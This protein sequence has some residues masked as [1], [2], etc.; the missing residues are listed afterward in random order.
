M[1]LNGSCLSSRQQPNILHATHDMRGASDINGER[2]GER[3]PLIG[4]IKQP[5]EN[6][7]AEQAR[8]RAGPRPASRSCTPPRHHTHREF[9][10]LHY[11]PPRTTHGLDWMEWD[12]M[13]S[14]EMRWNGM[15]W[16]GMECMPH[17]PTCGM[18]YIVVFFSFVILPRNRT[19]NNTLWPDWD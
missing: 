12:E 19:T 14:D 9:V 17:S 13:G 7:G 11:T 18:V 16:N 15:E 1:N 6:M 3:E 2:E 10:A 4:I 5:A 8:A